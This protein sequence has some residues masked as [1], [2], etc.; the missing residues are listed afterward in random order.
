MKT[1]K[2]SDGKVRIDGVLYG[3][4]PVSDVNIMGKSGRI[5]S[6]NIQ[7][8]G[9]FFPIS[10]FFDDGTIPVVD[11]TTEVLDEPIVKKK[12]K[13]TKLV[14]SNGEPL[15]EKG[16]LIGKKKRAKK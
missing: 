16:N 5:H 4:S 6:I 2:V 1:F 13:A 3:P 15:D 12:A 10:G 7:G 8:R 9:Q 14:E 11:S